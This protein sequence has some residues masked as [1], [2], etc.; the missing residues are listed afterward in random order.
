MK[1]K[2]KIIYDIMFDGGWEISKS[3]EIPHYLQQYCNY[4]YDK[5]NYRTL[6]FEDYLNELYKDDE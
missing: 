3:C 1:D 5:N 2:V 4:L 6:T